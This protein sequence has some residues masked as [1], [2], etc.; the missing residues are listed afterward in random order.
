MYIVLDLKSFLVISFQDSTLWNNRLHCAS[1]HAVHFLLV[2]FS[3]E[4]H[5][6]FCYIKHIIA[7]Q[8]QH[9]RRY[10]YAGLILFLGVIRYV[11]LFDFIFMNN[12][13]L[14][15]CRFMWLPKLEAIMWYFD[16]IPQHKLAFLFILISLQRFCSHCWCKYNFPCW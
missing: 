9:I 11:S 12:C 4:Y 8:Y 13:S 2:L 14:L 7:Y 3:F 15:H 6:C 10:W 5:I 1:P 16:H